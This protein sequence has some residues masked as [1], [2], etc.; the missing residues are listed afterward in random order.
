MFARGS[1]LSWLLWGDQ[2]NTD[3][4]PDWPTYANHTI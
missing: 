3:Y 1:R 2:A 4:E